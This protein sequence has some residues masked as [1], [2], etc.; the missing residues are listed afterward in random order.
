MSFAVFFDF[1]TGFKCD[2]YFEPGTYERVLS[3]IRETEQ[4][5]G[6]TRETYNG[7]CRWTRHPLVAQ[8]TPDDVYCRAVEKHNATVR[9]FYA[10]CT[11]APK[12]PEGGRTEKI[13][14][15]MAAEL[16]IGL[17]QITVPP[18]L[19]TDD[20]YRARMESMY[21]TLRGRPSEG[22]TFD[23]D[24]LSVKQ[25]RDVIVLFSQYLDT[26]DIRLDVCKGQDWLTESAGYFWC[27]QC[28]AVDY[29]DLPADFGTNTEH[30]DE[31]KAKQ[32]TV[33][34]PEL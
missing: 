34:N 21:D 32:D 12:Q 31:C 15:E 28:G 10:E 29:D 2:L 13:S 26:H 14:P 33:S 17:E 20:Y 8:D 24:A 18:E 11:K 30:C 16:F 25:A 3:R 23:S 4:Q 6:I 7:Q 19:W 9:W 27:S 5:L 22:M 1:S